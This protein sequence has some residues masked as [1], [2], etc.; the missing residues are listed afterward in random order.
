MLNSPKNNNDISSLKFSQMRKTPSRSG[1]FSNL[2]NSPQSNLNIVRLNEFI[3]HQNHIQSLR[4]NDSVKNSKMSKQRSL[5]IQFFDAYI[6]DD[7]Q[8]QEPTLDS[9]R[10]KLVHSKQI[11]KDASATCLGQQLSFGDKRIMNPYIPTSSF[12][13]K[14]LLE[15][16]LKPRDLKVVADSRP[17]ESHIEQN[18]IIAANFNI[19]RDN[20]QQF[21]RSPLAKNHRHN[22]DIIKSQLQEVESVKR[23]AA[24]IQKKK[25]K[26][27]RVKR[28]QAVDLY[29]EAKK[30]RMRA[31]QA[32]T[33]LVVSN[34]AKRLNQAYNDKF[35]ERAKARYGRILAVCLFKHWQ[36]TIFKNGKSL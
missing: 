22:L 13:E 30:K 25:W 4:V 8:N 35:D 6:E 33:F 7:D 15:F 11:R 2:N 28:E 16:K 34:M 12:K 36:K 31:N 29:I 20:L 19:Y 17:Q 9:E 1:S 10:R 5:E 21:K 3:K 26:E 27:F 32:F 24:G 23:E 14:T 18:K